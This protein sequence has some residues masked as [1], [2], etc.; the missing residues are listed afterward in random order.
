M[1]IKP[2]K[3]F[4]KFEKETE[5]PKLNVAEVQ[6]WR[7]FESKKTKRRSSRPPLV[8]GNTFVSGI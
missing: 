1:D 7:F 8:R 5:K 6:D 2:K 3:R 4:F